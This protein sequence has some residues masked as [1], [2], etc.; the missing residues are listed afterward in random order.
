VLKAAPNAA[1]IEGVPVCVMAHVS[2]NFVVKMTYAS[3]AIL[4]TIEK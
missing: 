1:P 4:V 3:P 2:V